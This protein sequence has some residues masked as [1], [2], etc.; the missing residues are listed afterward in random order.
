[1]AIKKEVT[2]DATGAVASF[3]VIAHLSVDLLNGTSSATLT[4][5]VSQ[6]TF[7]AGKQ[8]VQG[9]LPVF[10]KGVPASDQNAVAFLEAALIAAQPETVD[11]AEAALPY[12][13]NRYLFAGGS[14]AV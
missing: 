12:A 5:Y 13:A 2:L 7:Q 6:D 4:S 8:P 10:V 1:M 3:H 11:P 14:L 9:M